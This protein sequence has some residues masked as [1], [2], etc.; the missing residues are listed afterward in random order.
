MKAHVA[1]VSRCLPNVNEIDEHWKILIPP[2]KEKLE[3]SP[4]FFTTN[5][6]GKWITK[7]Q[8]VFFRPT[9]IANQGTSHESILFK[10]RF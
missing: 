4:I 7:E 8:A 9:K 1:T 3:H 5:E 2:L 10:G 6:G